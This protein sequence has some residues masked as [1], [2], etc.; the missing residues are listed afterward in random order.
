MRACFLHNQFQSSTTVSV[1]GGVEVYNERSFCVKYRSQ[2]V[3]TSF[4]GST[5]S[6][7]DTLGNTIP[8]GDIEDPG[9]ARADFPNASEERNLINIS[10]YSRV[11]FEHIQGMQGIWRVASKYRLKTTKPPHRR[12]SLSHHTISSVLSTIKKG[13]Y[14]F[15]IDLQDAYFNVLIHPHSRKY[16]FQVLHFSLNTA[17]QV[18]TCLR[19]RVAAYLHHQGISVIPYLD[20]WLIHH[21]D[22]QVLLR[23]QSQLLNILNM[24]GLRLNEA[25]S[26]LEPV[27]GASITLGLGE[28]FPPSIQSSGDMAHACRISSQK[29]LSYR[30]VSQFMESLNWGSGLIP[31][32][33][34]HYSPLQHFHSLGLTNRFSTPRRSDPLVLATLPRQWQN[35]SFLTSGI[36]I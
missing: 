2:G 6:A 30:E 27:S 16:Q 17:P 23:H 22:C 28:S 33:H 32:G 24:V 19:H 10:S 15:K 34:L 11:L 14:T 12:S 7:S 25:K 3:Q 9:N 18:F 36:P 20:D 8:P 13:D 26:E 4:Y 5:P 1:Y 35:L 29:T 31:L 21:P